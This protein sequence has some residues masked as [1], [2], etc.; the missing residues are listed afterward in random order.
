MRKNA[1]WGIGKLPLHEL[2]Q[3]PSGRWGFAG[4]VDARLAYVT[5][6]GKTPTANQFESARIAGPDIAGLKT[7]AWDSMEQA[8]IAAQKLG[9]K[10]GAFHGRKQNPS[11]F[12]KWEPYD[13]FPTE[14]M[15]R[16]YARQTKQ[17]NPSWLVKLEYSPK[18]GGATNPW[19]IFVVE[20]P[21]KNPE[22]ARRVGGG[23]AGARHTIL[24]N[25]WIYCE[26]Q[27]N[28]AAPVHT[29]SSVK[30]ALCGETLAG[31]H[32][33]GG[34]SD[35]PVPSDAYSGSWIITRRK[36]GEVIGEFFNKKEVERFDPKTCLIET[37][38][39]YLGRLNRDIKKNP[40]PSYALMVANAV[41]KGH[42]LE[43]ARELAARE[44]EQAAI[45]LRE[46]RRKNPLGSVVWKSPGKVLGEFK[47][48]PGFFRSRQEAI[49]K[50]QEL[51]RV[52]RV[53][54]RVVVGINGYYDVETDT[55]PR[56]KNPVVGS[57]KNLSLNSPTQIY[58]QLDDIRM[59]KT[60][61]D[62]KAPGGRKFEHKF[63][64]GVKAVG[65]PRNT[66]LTT[67][68]GKQMKA[69]RRVVVLTAKKDLWGLFNN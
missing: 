34:V 43:Q 18:D 19:V 28:S 51:A 42:P 14:K 62:A 29:T 5:K 7:R 63:S 52:Y 9:I 66:V 26:E 47:L 33:V 54:S 65:F 3:Y 45:F 13:A 30:C 39:Q 55:T 48:W 41:R 64:K 2:I 56:R 50:A 17:S 57:R 11:T 36:T 61:A 35:N 59:R 53:T 1:V 67:P 20:R 49:R 16:E 4:R 31:L 38:G 22:T 25:G 68:D 46:P 37:A 10:V 8:I 44:L 27:A 23:T 12:H 6:D 21:R 40:V 24:R 58:G 15:G 69:T 32:Y 60:A